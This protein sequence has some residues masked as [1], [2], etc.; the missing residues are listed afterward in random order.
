M[1]AKTEEYFSGCL[2]ID[3]GTTYSCVAVWQSDHVEIIPNAL[4]NRTTP[5]WIAFQGNE[6]LIGESAKHA[7][8]IAGLN[9]LRIVNEPTASCLA[10]GLQKSASGFLLVFDLGGG[11]LDVS[12]LEIADDLYEVRAT[13]GNTRLGGQDIDHRLVTYF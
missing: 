12:L 9:C 11:T 7:A 3:L 8:Q 6:C 1:E 13:N 10:Y 5:S 4:G 2:G